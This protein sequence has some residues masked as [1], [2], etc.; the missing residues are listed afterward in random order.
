MSLFYQM[1]LIMIFAQCEL[2]P[3]VFM[4]VDEVLQEYGA[5]V[6]SCFKDSFTC[7]R[8]KTA[9]FYPCTSFSLLNMIFY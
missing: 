8:V 1:V 5:L 6:D 7:S 4:R 9:T 2:K 3:L